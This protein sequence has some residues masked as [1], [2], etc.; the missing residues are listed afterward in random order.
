MNE[1]ESGDFSEEFL[2]W[3]GQKKSEYLS[4]LITEQGPDDL[5]FETYHQFD[6]LIQSTV[7]RP[8][9]SWITSKEDY[10][11]R[12]FHR[13]YARE[14]LVQIVVLASE[15]TPGEALPILSLVTRSAKVI[16][17]FRIGTRSAGAILQ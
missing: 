17:H 15:K 11:L 3:V 8:D 4:W 13:T 10:P 9:E 1:A 16:A 6:H 7:E 2:E 14:D 5:G 12:I